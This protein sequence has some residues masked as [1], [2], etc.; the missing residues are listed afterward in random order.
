[1]I[2]FSACLLLLAWLVPD[3][4]GATI[5]YV[6]DYRSISTSWSSDGGFSGD[7]S[8]A[9]VFGESWSDSMY[10]GLPAIDSTLTATHIT[11]HLSTARCTYWEHYDE[12]TWT[13]HYYFGPQDVAVAR[14]G[15]MVTEPTSS[16]WERDGATWNV[17]LSPGTLYRIDESLVATEFV[18]TGPPVRHRT[19][20]MTLVPEP[21][22][23]ALVVMGL[24]LV[25]RTRDPRWPAS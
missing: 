10:G 5:I 21:G 22:T 7:G 24:S 4:A 20:S 17:D 9:P 8:T 19:F 14:I 11:L 3:V 23:A 6:S 18:N 16:I 25:A 15:F 12:Q 13:R 1:M 2:R